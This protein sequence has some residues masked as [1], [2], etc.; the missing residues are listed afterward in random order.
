M[1]DP[2]TEPVDFRDWLTWYE[3]RKGGRRRR[4]AAVDERTVMAE[5]QAAADET[6]Q[7]SLHEILAVTAK[8]T[9]VPGLLSSPPGAPLAR[10]ELEGCRLD[11][12][13]RFER[14]GAR[15]ELWADVVLNS[16]MTGERRYRDVRVRLSRPE[17]L[18]K[19]LAGKPL[20]PRPITF[21]TLVTLLLT[22]EAFRQHREERE[23]PAANLVQVVAQLR[24]PD[25]AIPRDSV[26]AVLKEDEQ[27]VAMYGDPRQGP[28]KA[29]A[30]A[31]YNLLKKG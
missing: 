17:E 21:D 8:P 19:Y 9:F 29:W 11:L 30:R 12:I 4:R 18:D 6:Y 3:R 7:L 10:W 20:R 26:R 16:R 5:L 28:P 13:E 23:P 14:L 27:V 31:I 24:F 2:T 25:L 15:I 22:D 1:P